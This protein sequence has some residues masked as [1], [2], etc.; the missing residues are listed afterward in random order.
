MSIR[1]KKI[2]LLLLAAVAPERKRRAAQHDPDEHECERHVQRDGE[3]CERSGEAGKQQHHRE[4]QPDVVGLPHRTD[5]VRDQLALPDLAR[6]ARQQIPH[7]AAEVRA[8]QQ[9]IRV[10]RDQDDA[11]EQVRETHPCGLRTICR[12][13]SH[14]TIAPSAQ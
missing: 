5:G 9:H 7:A 13:N 3:A 8:A 6:P 11:G 4:D 10:E 2:L 14:V 1:A 12:Y